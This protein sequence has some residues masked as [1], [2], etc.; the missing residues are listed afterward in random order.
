MGRRAG[1]TELGRHLLAPLPDQRCRSE[2][3]HALGHA[4][5]GILLQHHAGLDGLAEAD[6]VGEQDPSA[7]LF[8]HLANGLDLVPQGLDTGE[9][10]QAEKLVEALREAEMSKAFAQPR[11]AAAGLGRLFQGGDQR[12]RIEL[13]RERDVEL[14]AGRGGTPLAALP[15]V[16]PRAREKGAARARR[17]SIR[18]QP[19]PGPAAG[20]STIPGG[21]RCAVS[22]GP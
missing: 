5:Q 14:D 10:R 16:A 6:L 19:S 17:P 4:A 13:D 12:C 18:T 3:Q 8:Q 1:Q 21:L 2:H 7:E 11:K 22:R 20:G 15:G 9:M